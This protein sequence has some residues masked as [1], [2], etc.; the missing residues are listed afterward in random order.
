[1]QT[2]YDP[3][4]YFNICAIIRCPFRIWLLSEVCLNPHVYLFPFRHFP[5]RSQATQITIW[6]LHLFFSSNTIVTWHSL[7]ILRFRSFWHSSVLGMFAVNAMK[8]KLTFPL[9]FFLLFFLSLCP[10]ELRPTVSFARVHCPRRRVSI[11]FYA[12]NS[13]NTVTPIL[14]DNTST[15]FSDQ[16]LEMSYF[17]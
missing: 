1:M 5:F 12:S 2:W 7:Q 9:F 8:K 13:A 16:G 15:S 17:F 6:S 11:D 14:I 10:I 3:F 4:Q